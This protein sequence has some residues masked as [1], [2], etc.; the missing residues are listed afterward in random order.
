ME[1]RIQQPDVCRKAVEL[2][3]HGL[4]VT[5]LHREKLCKC[6]LSLDKVI[7]KDHLSHGDYPASAEEHVFCSAKA[8]TLCTEHDCHMSVLRSISIGPDAHCL[9]LIDIAHELLVVLEQ[10]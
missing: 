9:D 1:R 3:E 8:N 2:T 7:G 5:S 4:E 10:C 6:C